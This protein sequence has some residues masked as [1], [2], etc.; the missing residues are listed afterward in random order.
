MD[1]EADFGGVMMICAKERNLWFTSWE[2]ECNQCKR[3]CLYLVLIQDLLSARPLN[4]VE[5][6]KSGDEINTME[7]GREILKALLPYLSYYVEFCVILSLKKKKNNNTHYEKMA[8]LHSSGVK[9]SIY[10][11]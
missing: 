2:M 6:W 8:L 11:C 5:G 9:T 3:S 1:S 7:E 10:C 4:H